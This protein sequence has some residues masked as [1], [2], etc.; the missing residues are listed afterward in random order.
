MD[1]Q[2]LTGKISRDILCPLAGMDGFGRDVRCVTVAEDIA[3]AQNFSGGELVLSSGMLLPDGSQGL[4][5]SISALN[6]A[7]CAGLCLRLPPEAEWI[8]GEVL[9][10]AD[11]LRFPLFGIRSPFSMAEISKMLYRRADQSEHPDFEYVLASIRELSEMTLSGGGLDEIIAMIARKLSNTVMFL[12]PQLV[13]S[14]VQ[15]VLREVR[16][17]DFYPSKGQRFFTP[18][19]QARLEKGFAG[20]SPQLFQDR[21]IRNGE[22]VSFILSPARWGESLTGYLCILSTNKPFSLLE[23]WVVENYLP[24]LAQ[25]MRSKVQAEASALNMDDLFMWQVLLQ[26]NPDSQRAKQF[27]ALCNFD[28]DSTRICIVMEYPS[29][30]AMPALQ[31]RQALEK[32][33]AHISRRLAEHNDMDKLILIHENTLTILRLV[34]AGMPRIAVILEHEL[35]GTQMVQEISNEFGLDCFIGLSETCRGLETLSSCYF[36]AAESIALGKKIRPS[37]SCFSYHEQYLFHRLWHNFT[38]DELHAICVNILEPIMGDTPDFAELRRTLEAYI[39]CTGN[40]SQTAER[41]YI[42]RNTLNYRMA[43]LKNLLAVT[44]ISADD[45]TRYMVGLTILK[46]I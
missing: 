31:R 30:A 42:H 4:M 17:G 40:L 33:R 28:Y 10:H 39:S 38:T 45:F 35:L 34:P 18:S 46:M 29:L 8:S 9:R 20:Q 19:E 44:E 25:T 13:I 22:P 24:V 21:L 23:L 15:T 36:E 43:K 3:A 7:G 26:Q 5:E 32:Q 41:L 37:Q 16:K 14:S 27:C 1:V 2:L 6:E 12:T 11:A